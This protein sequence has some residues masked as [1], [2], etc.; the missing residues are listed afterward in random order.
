MSDP[1]H[2]TGEQRAIVDQSAEDRD[3]ADDSGEIDDP[4]ALVETYPAAFDAKIAEA[5]KAIKTETAGKNS[6]LADITDD[7]T[8]GVSRVTERS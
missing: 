3:P 2:V 7:E 5:E 1:Q 4:S 8:T 6:D